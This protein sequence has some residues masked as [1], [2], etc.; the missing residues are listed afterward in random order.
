M[1]HRK[2]KFFTSD[3][4]SPP[5]HLGV[6]LLFL[7]VVEILSVF[8]LFFSDGDAEKQFKL[9][10]SG[11]IAITKVLQLM[12][13]AFRENP[14]GDSIFAIFN[15]GLFARLRGLQRSLVQLCVAGVCLILTLALVLPR[16]WQTRDLVRTNATIPV[17][18]ALS[19]P[20]YNF[21]YSVEFRANGETQT[22]SFP[23]VFIGPD[24][25]DTIPVAY[26]LDDPQIAYPAGKAVLYGGPME[27]GLLG[28]AFLVL[29]GYPECLIRFWLC[30]Q[31]QEESHRIIWEDDSD[32]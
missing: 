7:A 25:K 11:M 32:E 27:I 29:S 16:V 19:G 12:Y 31:Q 6:I 15:Y 14:W 17:V 23:A 9:I 28:L 3:K 24:Y 22:A 4:K 5:V 18:S 26:A 30:G 10:L 20:V 13:E 8:G 1:L 2:H 21:R